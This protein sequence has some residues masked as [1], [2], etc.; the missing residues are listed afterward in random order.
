MLDEYAPVGAGR[1][2]ALS[3]EVGRR[4]FRAEQLDRLPVCR[5]RRPHQILALRGEQPR[6]G[7]VLLL[8]QLAQLLDAFVLV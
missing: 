3:R 1:P 6:C 8:V 7:A 2:A 5:K 4:S